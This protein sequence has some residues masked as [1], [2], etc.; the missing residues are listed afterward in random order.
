MGVADL[1]RGRVTLECTK[2]VEASRVEVTVTGRERVVLQK[3]GN[4]AETD[5]APF[6]HVQGTSH[7]EH[8]EH[9]KVPTLLRGEIDYFLLVQTPCS[10]LSSCCLCLLSMKACAFNSYTH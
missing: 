3:T 10:V 7:R 8:Q 2:P 6:M 4:I 5:L 1:A 9:I